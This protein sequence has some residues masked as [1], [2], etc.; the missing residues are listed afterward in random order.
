MASGASRLRSTLAVHIPGLAR[1][2]PRGLILGMRPL[3]SGSMRLG[4]SGRARRAMTAALGHPPRPE[5]VRAYFDRLADQA[6]F[7]ALVARSNLRDSGVTACWQPEPGSIERIRRSLEGGR[8]AVLAV[9]HLAGTEIAAGAVS[10]Q[11]PIT[12]LARRSHEAPYQ[13]FKEQWYAALGVK[14]SWRPRRGGGL[15]EVTGA[16][17]VLRSNEVLAITPD[18]HPK[19]GMGVTVRLFEREVQLPAGPFFLAVRTGAALV[20]VFFHHAD[21]VYRLRS[22]EPLPIRDPDRDTAVALMAQEWTALFEAWLKR[23]PEMWQFWL[24]K[25]WSRWL[26]STARQGS[27][28]GSE[29]AGARCG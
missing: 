26:L 10:E 12:L 7:S 24:D 14:V 22:E 28:P 8:G 5:Q 18:V 11:I 17:R 1:R 16:L 29:E 3:I 19:P 23:Y 13:T 6:A 21:G 25:R 20:P 27:E 4:L 15:E 2:T 9:P